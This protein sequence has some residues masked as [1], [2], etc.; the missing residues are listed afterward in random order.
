M[1][2]ASETRNDSTQLFEFVDVARNIQMDFISPL[3]WDRT[4]SREVNFRN[5]SV[6]GIFLLYLPAQLWLVNIAEG[7]ARN[8]LWI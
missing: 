7:G 5:S 3:A 8:S 4:D 1:K 2:R 6:N